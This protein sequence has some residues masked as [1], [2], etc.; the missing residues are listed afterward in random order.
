MS[1]IVNEVLSANEA[2]AASFG[3]KAGLA[4]PPARGPATMRSARW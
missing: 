1:N 3:D 2:Y 4:M